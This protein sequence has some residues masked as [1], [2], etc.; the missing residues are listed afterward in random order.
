MHA[1]FKRPIKPN[2]RTPRAPGRFGAG[3]LPRERWS[4]DYGWLPGR[5]DAAWAAQAFAGEPGR[6]WDREA[7]EAIA[8]DAMG[9]LTPLVGICLLCGDR[10]D[11][12]EQ[13]L[14]DHCDAMATEATIAG[15]NERSG[16]GYK[17]W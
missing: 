7:G 1:T 13:G 6:E 17:V 2:R 12:T 14:C 16:S 3:I 15:E 4:G 8:I 5:D 9:S 10:D 11:L